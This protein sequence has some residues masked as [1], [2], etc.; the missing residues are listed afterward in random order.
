MPKCYCE[1]HFS[2]LLQCQVA[3]LATSAVHQG[4]EKQSLSF[5]L[6]LMQDQVS[7]VYSG[8]QKERSREGMISSPS[9]LWGCEGERMKFSSSRRSTLEGQHSLISPVIRPLPTGRR[10]RVSHRHQLGFYKQCIQISLRT[11][12]AKTGGSLVKKGTVFHQQC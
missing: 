8:R 7:C 11:R 5:S 4:L 6:V 1:L 9:R 2:W 3:S 10:R 12:S